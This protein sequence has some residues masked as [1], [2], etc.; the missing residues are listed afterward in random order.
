MKKKKKKKKKKELEFF[1]NNCAEP[2]CNSCAATIHDGHVKILLEEAANERK[3]EIKS[4]VESQM[5]RAQ[6]MG[7]KITKLDENYVKIQAQVANVKRGVQQFADDMMA[8]IEA[9]KQGMLKELDNQGQ[10]S[11]QRLEKQRRKMEDGVRMF[12]KETEKM[13][14]F[15]DEAQA[16]R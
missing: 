11:L 13:K 2:I 3:L 1:C 9:M 14:H 15:L 16:L 8:V 10:Q 6:R 12:E 5:E 4:V 7:N